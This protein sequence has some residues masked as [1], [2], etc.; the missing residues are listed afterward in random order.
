MKFPLLLTAVCLSG[1][2]GA[3]TIYVNNNEAF[4]AD[5]RTFDEAYAAA[6]ADDT[7]ILAGSET[8]YGTISI[9]DKP[10]KL[11]GNGFND[12]GAPNVAVRA[13]SLR[14]E[15][16]RLSIGADASGSPEASEVHKANGSQV[17][18]VEMNSCIIYS[19]QCQIDRCDLRS[20]STVYG[21]L[22]SFTRCETNSVFLTETTLT[23]PF[24]DDPLRVIASGALFQNCE[25][26]GAASPQTSA[27]TSATVEQ[28]VINIDGS[29]QVGFFTGS[30]TTGSAVFRNCIV[31]NYHDATLLPV[32]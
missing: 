31:G 11:V 18:G 28:C 3:E 7:I 12:E 16:G 4:P 14:T 2:L 26:R 21:S 13:D 9:V 5:Y 29:Q 25:F 32:L 20:A 19:S 27:N 6:S 8:S 24:P 10:I 22:T 30:Y 23:R 15:I 1:S 17:I